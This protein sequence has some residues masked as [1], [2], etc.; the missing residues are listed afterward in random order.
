M[1]LAKKQK[2]PKV[3]KP[4]YRRGW[5]IALMIIFV[6]AGMTSG[7]SDKKEPDIVKQE[8]A[9]IAALVETKPE[10]VKVEPKAETPAVEPKVE[11][12]AVEPKVEEAKVEP[13]V[14]VLVTETAAKMQYIGNATSK[15]FHKSTC[16]SLPKEGNR[17]FFDTR[18]EALSKGYKGCKRCN[19]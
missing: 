1:A 3:K 4:V 7:S 17:T 14:E 11:I 16:S 10:I 6:I 12:A 5:L 2:V 8:K 9:P 13:K 15:K 19:P 18:D